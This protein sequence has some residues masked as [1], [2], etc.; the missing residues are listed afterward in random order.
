MIAADDYNQ[1]QVFNEGE[2]Y[3]FFKKLFRRFVWN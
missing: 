3:I 2:T 1:D